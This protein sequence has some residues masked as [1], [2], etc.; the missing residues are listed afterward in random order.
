IIT[1]TQEDGH[2]RI[3]IE[4]ENNSEPIIIQLGP[5]NDG[6]IILKGKKVG[7][8]DENKPVIIHPGEG[9]S[10]E[11]RLF[12]DFAP[13]SFEYQFEMPDLKALKET[14]KELEKTLKKFEDENSFNDGETTAALHRALAER[15][16]IMAERNRQIQEHMRELRE[17]MNAQLE[18]NEH[19]RAAL[20]EQVRKEHQ[21]VMEENR[22]IAEEHR[23]LLQEKM[24]AL[25]EATR[26]SHERRAY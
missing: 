11:N 17:R 14:E 7:D 15:Q 12:F 13:G 6:V 24:E 8:L 21:R 22:K 4:D 23:R 20:R 5:D 10:D 26:K 3:R 1:R 19:Q 9:N 16:K 25:R 2:T 18:L